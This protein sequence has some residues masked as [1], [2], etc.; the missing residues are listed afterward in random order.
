VGG[1]N[2]LDFFSNELSPIAENG[3]VRLI[4]HFSNIAIIL[5]IDLTSMLTASPNSIIDSLFYINYF[6]DLLF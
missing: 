6:C 2:L 5:N 1:Y 3:L 4:V